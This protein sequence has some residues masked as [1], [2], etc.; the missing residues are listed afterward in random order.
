MALVVVTTVHLVIVVA[1][2]GASPT[3]EITADPL[4][5]DAVPVVVAQPRGNV[6][7]VSAAAFSFL[8]NVVVVVLLAAGGAA[9][10]SSP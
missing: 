7:S 4:S 1:C 3:F 2:V 5:S 6:T 9:W 8:D 10:D